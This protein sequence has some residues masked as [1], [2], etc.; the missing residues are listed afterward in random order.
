MI[1]AAEVNIKKLDG[2]DM[3]LEC[4]RAGIGSLKAHVLNE[5]FAISDEG[6]AIQG[7]KNISDLFELSIEGVDFSELRES[8]IKFLDTAGVKYTEEQ[9]NSPG[10]LHS[11][12]ILDDISVFDKTS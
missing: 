4:S 12:F 11:R 9:F 8:V 5:G 7:T 6:I 1:F 2:F 10:D 3:T